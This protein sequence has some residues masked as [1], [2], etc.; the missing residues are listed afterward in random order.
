ML[1]VEKKLIR[2]PD[3]VELLD[4]KTEVYD[5]CCCPGDSG[6]PGDEFECADDCIVR[7]MIQPQN[8]VSESGGIRL[9]Y[10]CDFLDGMCD[11][12][13]ITISLTVE[14]ISNLVLSG[15]Q[16]HFFRR[17]GIEMVPSGPNT[18]N[19]GSNW[20]ALDSSTGGTLDKD[21]PTPNVSQYYFEDTVGQTDLQLGI[22]ESETYEIVLDLDF[23]FTPPA[24]ED[25]LALNIYG[26]V[27]VDPLAGGSPYSAN[28]RTRTRYDLCSEAT[29]PP[30]E[31]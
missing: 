13:Q 11:E 29:I 31:L 2:F 30:S 5:P 27:D 25:N 17:I 12:D 3:T 1:R 22:G 19:G 24:G 8:V 7:S 4:E 6:A 16:A 26:R 23:A 9:T 15:D 10:D 18:L 21:L 14:N 28:C 20:C